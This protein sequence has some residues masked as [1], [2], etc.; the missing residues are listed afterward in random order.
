MRWPR[1]VDSSCSGRL[2]VAV[3]QPW[4]AAAFS[5]GGEGGGKRPDAP[6]DFVYLD[7]GDTNFSACAPDRALWMAGIAAI[8][9]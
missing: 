9:K 3:A 4:R 5:A 7:I 6:L 8:V 2:V 1:G